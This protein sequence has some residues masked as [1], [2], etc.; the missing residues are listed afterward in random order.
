[1]MA[2]TKLLNRKSTRSWNSCLLPLCF[3]VDTQ[4]QDCQLGNLT[5]GKVY[6]GGGKDPNHFIGECPKSS[7]SNNKKAFIGGAWSDSGNDEEEKAKDET[8]LVAQ[9]SNEI[10]LGINLEPG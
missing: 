8:C 5:A 4:T 1:T 10:C 3:F 6:G 2:V 9:A 7:R